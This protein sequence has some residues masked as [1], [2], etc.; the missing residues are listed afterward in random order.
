M[1]EPIQE[2]EIVE[3]AANSARRTWVLWLGVGGVLVLLCAAAF[4]GA[5][6]LGGPQFI[7]QYLPDFIR[8]ANELT[9][10][11][12]L[13]NTMG[14]PNAPVHIVEYVDF[15]CPF[16]LRFWKETEPQ[17]IEEYVNTG[18][19]Y[20]EYRSYPVLGPESV[21]AAEAAYCARDQ[22][23]FW[24][25]HDIMFTNWT[26]EN[27]G[28]FTYEKLMQYAESIDL[29]MDEFE[30]C[31]SEGKHKETVEQDRVKAEA[32]GVH[33]TPTFLINGTRVEGAQ[34]FDVFKHIIE[35]ILNGDFDTLN[36]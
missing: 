2:T 33:A 10:D 36:G 20:F 31:V 26:G 25:F 15:Q 3:P 24:E 12:T 7:D 28:D 1:E 22:G 11:I 5:L 16:C 34:P 9:R 30:Q 17:L 29:D 21:L 19:V 27:V 4:V 13:N 8:P 14:D 23:R 6:I 18:R 35:Q 32:D